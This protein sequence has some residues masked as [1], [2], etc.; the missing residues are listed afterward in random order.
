[1]IEALARHRHFGRAAAELGIS[2]PGLT[3]SLKHLE[4][5]LGVQLF[6]RDGVV[7]ATLFGEIILSRSRSVLLDFDEIK[8]EIALAKGLD[9]GALN[10]VA[11]PYPTEI[12][13]QKAIGLLSE[14]HPSILTRLTIKDWTA[15]ADDIVAGRADIAVADIDE[16][17]EH[18]DL[19]VE[20][21]RTSMMQF[22]CRADH[23]LTARSHLALEDLIEFPW[24]GPSG[25][26]RMR[27]W[28]SAENKA[29]GV[30]DAA[31]NRFH[32]RVLVETFDAARQ[33]VAC[34]NG[35]SVA[36]P[37]M[38]SDDIRNGKLAILPVEAKWMRLNYGVIWKR[39]RSLSPSALRFTDLVRSI[40][41]A[42]PG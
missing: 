28:L 20:L 38:I 4:D 7:T 2:Q 24:V 27:A 11:A 32:P 19:E 12:S 3:R 41:R 9:T 33:I 40:E 8:R 23:P 17:V 36:V 16:A 1:M 15:A 42:M 22:F 6:N 30:F 21:L 13:V 18:S 26:A 37:A 5:R 35:I 10:V 14:R 25:P 34:G 31:S 29:F 39:G